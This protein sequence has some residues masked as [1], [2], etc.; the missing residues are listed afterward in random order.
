MLCHV[1]KSLSNE[2]LA[3]GE[4]LP[5]WFWAPP[6][7]ADIRCSVGYANEY[8]YAASSYNAAFDNAA[9]RIWYDRS[10]RIK[11]NSGILSLH[12]ETMFLEGTSQISTDTLGFA[13]FKGSL[14]RVDSCWVENLVL[15]LVSTRPITVETNLTAPPTPPVEFDSL[16]GLTYGVG[17]APAYYYSSSSWLDAEIDARLEMA[18][19]AFSNVRVHVRMF[20]QLYGRYS[21]RKADVLAKDIRV[22][23]RY[24]DTAMGRHVVVVA[25]ERESIRPYPSVVQQS[26]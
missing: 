24:L 10:S 13:A 3:G 2:C 16:P 12:D 25:T 17:H 11:V 15:M 7:F 20:D 26:N 9:L 6:V 8:E 4:Y 5:S 14:V 19:C 21:I 22:V 23:A 18:L 1:C